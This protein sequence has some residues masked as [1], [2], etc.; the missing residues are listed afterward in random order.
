MGKEDNSQR[1]QVNQYRTT[2]WLWT[3]LTHASDLIH[4][5]VCSN[6]A[7]PVTMV[8]TTQVIHYN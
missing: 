5:T 2:N 4:H 6:G 7:L 8:I 3:E 1:E